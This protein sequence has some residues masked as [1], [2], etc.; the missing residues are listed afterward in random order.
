[1]KQLLSRGTNGSSGYTAV[2][3]ALQGVERTRRAR[4][5]VAFL[6]DPM[7]V[8]LGVLIAMCAVLALPKCAAPATASG[9]FGQFSCLRLRPPSL[10]S[11]A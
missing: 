10:R 7:I 2:R 8:Y 6:R 1:M 4:A 3:T 5:I 11:N 9:N